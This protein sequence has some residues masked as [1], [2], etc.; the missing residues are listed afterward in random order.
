MPSLGFLVSYLILS[1][2]TKT[3]ELKPEL[4]L[5]MCNL[6]RTE[7]YYCNSHWR[8]LDTPIVE[9]RNHWKIPNTHLIFIS[10]LIGCFIFS[11]FES[12]MEAMFSWIPYQKLYQNT[13]GFIHQTV[14]KCS[15]N[16]KKEILNQQ[17]EIPL[18]STDFVRNSKKNENNPV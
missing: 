18:Q 3:V 9:T 15:Q 12:I 1:N 6:N 7:L 10:V 16:P 4:C 13:Q 5:N 14:P 2:L 11:T 17:E 8:H